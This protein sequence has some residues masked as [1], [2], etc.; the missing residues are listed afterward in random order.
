[1]SE[2][3]NNRKVVIGRKGE[4][5]L[6]AQIINLEKSSEN[7]VGGRG[8]FRVID[9]ICPNCFAVSRL[10]SEDSQTPWYRCWN[11]YIVCQY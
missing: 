6:D 5:P 9:V 7:E 2:E 4:P 10:I 1:M 11:C 3:S 8:D